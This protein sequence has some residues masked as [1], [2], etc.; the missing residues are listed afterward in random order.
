MSRQGVG[1]SSWRLL[2]DEAV[3][4]MSRSVR[5]VAEQ[6]VT[7]VRHSTSVFLEMQEQEEERRSPP[8]QQ[9]RRTPDAVGC[10]AWE[11]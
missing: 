10:E 7:T 3:S 4:V 6:S 1:R 5:R 11:D 9:R 8:M 2:V